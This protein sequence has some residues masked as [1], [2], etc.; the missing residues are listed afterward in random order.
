MILKNP[1]KIVSGYF[2]KSLNLTT[3]IIILNEFTIQ[4][5]VEDAAINIL[6][7]TRELENRRHIKNMVNEKLQVISNWTEDHI[8]SPIAIVPCENP[9][10]S[11]TSETKLNIIL[12]GLK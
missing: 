5:L 10:T 7:I 2:E 1:L 4:K 8:I 3:S 12:I 6:T 9:L 11:I